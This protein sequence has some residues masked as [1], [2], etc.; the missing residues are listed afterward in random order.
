MDDDFNTAQGI[1][2]L[3][4]MIRNVNRTLDASE[5]NLSPE[6]ISS[7]RSA[8]DDLSGMGKILGILNSDTGAYF[9]DK[10]QRGLEDASVDAAWVEKMIQERTDA[11]KAKDWKRADEIRDELEKM[12]ILL[13]DRPDGTI[14][15]AG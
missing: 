10:K 7:I 4:E 2:V 1:G 9:G 6:K 3:F 15:K 11:R 5:G 13:E 12:N 14:W 8:Y